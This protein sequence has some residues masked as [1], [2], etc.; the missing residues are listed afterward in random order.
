M[1][2][3]PRLMT[4]M[5]IVCAVSAIGVAGYVLYMGR[6][7]VA[8]FTDIGQFYM[9]AKMM[10][11]HDCSLLYK[12]VLVD[13]HE[14]WKLFPEKDRR[15]F[16]YLPPFSLPLLL[17]FG[18]VPKQI[19]VDVFSALL[20]ACIVA[21][22]AILIKYFRLNVKQSCTLI[23]A[24]ALSAPV[25][26]SLRIGQL[27]PI[28]FL[29][30]VL[31]M[32]ALKKERP[33]LAG[34]AMVG[35]IFKPQELAPYVLFLLGA[36]RYKPILVLAVA[37]AILCGVSYMFIGMDGFKDYAQLITAM[38]S[39]SM[40]SA[41]ITPT[42]RGQ[43]LKLFPASADGIGL[44]GVVIMLIGWCAIFLIGRELKDSEQWMEDG[45]AAWMPFAIVTAMYWHYYDMLVLMPGLIALGT[46]GYWSQFPSICRAILL[47]GSLFFLLPLY[48]FVHYYY[49]L[50]MNG[51]I[52]PM[53]WTMLS[54]NICCLCA[55]L[56]KEDST[57]VEVD[58]EPA[59]SANTSPAELDC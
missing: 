35:M 18:L 19:A 49:V 54:F 57:S 3:N 27:G 44:I 38:R 34:L 15:V 11:D 29:S 2:P 26:E 7:Y 43:L 23:C 55:V 8:L 36:R 48:I 31:S 39:N 4:I 6:Q 21:G 30:L 5:Y 24:S 20:F 32:V 16:T 47:M 42:I 17:P 46:R 52:N 51:P 22:T 41:E 56:W 25:Y 28:L 53:F 37:V 1:K 59:G 40:M 12:T 45:L 13:G 50:G 58:D 9:N 10:L 33:S 14:S